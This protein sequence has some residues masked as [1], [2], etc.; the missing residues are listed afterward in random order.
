[1]SSYQ[2]CAL[3]GAS[4]VELTVALYDG[5]IRFMYCAY[6]GRGATKPGPTAC[7]CKTRH[8]HRDPFASYAEDGYW[9]KASRG[10]LRVLHGDVCAN[11]AGFTGEFESEI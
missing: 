2:T 10:P 11:A 1:M 6:L 7:R 5:I 9:R 3:E 4:A 8:G